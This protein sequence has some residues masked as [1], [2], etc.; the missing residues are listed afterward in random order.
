MKTK[1]LLVVSMFSVLLL[2]NSLKISV[3]AY[4]QKALDQLVVT[5]KCIG[6]DFRDAKPRMGSLLNV[7]V[8]ISEF[9]GSEQ[10]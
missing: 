3:L 2:T 10:R 5:R 8:G 9:L 6:C 1:T 7:F 4:K